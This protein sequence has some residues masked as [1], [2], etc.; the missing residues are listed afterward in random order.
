MLIA[1]AQ[2]ETLTLVTADAL[3]PTYGVETVW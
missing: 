3:V 2:H 1:Q